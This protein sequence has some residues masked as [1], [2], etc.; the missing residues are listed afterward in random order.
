MYRFA[1]GVE[2]DGAGYCGWQKQVSINLET[3][4]GKLEEALS[5]VANYSIRTT[6]AGR[7]DSGVH[8]TNQ[9][10]HFD[11]P[12][13]RGNKAWIY[14]VNSLLPPSIRV[15][16]VKAVDQSFHARFSATARRYKYLI[17]CQRAESVFLRKKAVWV[18]KDLDV[19][20]MNDATG[21]L[22][23]EHDFSG[24]RAAGCQSRSSRR[25]VMEVSWYKSGKF[26]VFDVKAN[27]FLLH[28]VRNLVGAFLDVGSGVKDL[29][30]ISE[31]LDGR[32]RS[33]G[34]VTAPPD[35]LYL[36]AVDYP[37]QH[38]LPASLSIPIFLPQ[39]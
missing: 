19:K 32:D 14:G 15:T 7:T 9:V 38:M 31:V 13:D 36:V 22:L 5:R 12:V 10:V 3:V 25:F 8:A 33:A 37:D 39:A 24:F 2:Y 4:Q 26:I 30:W 20:L 34:S 27:A 23:G 17:Y 11:T 1:L 21:V 6:C 16:W 35:G 29:N 28:M 18:K